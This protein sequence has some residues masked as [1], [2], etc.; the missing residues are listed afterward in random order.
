ATGQANAFQFFEVPMIGSAA[1]AVTSLAFKASRDVALAAGLAGGTL[2]I[3][4][5]FYEPRGRTEIYIAGHDAMSCIQRLS[6]RADLIYTDGDVSAAALQSIRETLGR[7]TDP[8]KRSALQKVL[9]V[10]STGPGAIDDAITTV[11]SR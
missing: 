7:E 5:S 10:A 1:T 11:N 9:T 8:T 6:T 2:A 3:L 4:E